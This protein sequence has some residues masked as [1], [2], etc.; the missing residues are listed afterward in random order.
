MAES[1]DLV[2]AK[3]LLDQAKL[4]GFQF[5]RIAPG[6][7]GSLE[8]TRCA[9]GWRDTVHLGG[10]SSDCYAWRERT[11]ALIVP[12]GALVGP[13]VRGS[14]LSVLNDVLTWPTSP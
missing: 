12:E 2:T 11:S 1:P 14:A 13:R 9:G 5:R 7:D 6:P 8:G 3:R 4:R 10:F